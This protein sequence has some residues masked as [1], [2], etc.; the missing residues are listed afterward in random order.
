MIFSFGSYVFLP[1]KRKNISFM[2]VVMKTAGLQ[3]AQ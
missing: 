3:L 1:L 2:S